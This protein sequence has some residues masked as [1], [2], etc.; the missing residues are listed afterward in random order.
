MKITDRIKTKL[1]YPYA[2]LII[3]L[4][5]FLAFLS[6][7][8]KKDKV[9]FEQP[10]SG[11]N[12]AILALYNKGKLRADIKNLLTVLKNNGAYVIAINTLK[13]KDDELD[14]HIDCYIER[15]N[16]G[17]DFGIFVHLHRE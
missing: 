11:E 14:N 8:L 15:P 1:I 16:Y 13:L 12:I 10:Y 3:S 9:I 6:Q 2:Y 4:K 17:R 5:S 7:I